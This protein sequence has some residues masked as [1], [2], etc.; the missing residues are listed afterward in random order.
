MIQRYEEISVQHAAH[1]ISNCARSDY[2]RCFAAYRNI[3][4]PPAL[5]WPKVA[6]DFGVGAPFWTLGLFIG[7]AIG[8][9]TFT[10]QL[11]AIFALMQLVALFIL[12]AFRY[13]LYWLSDR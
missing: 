10:A 3:W 12:W 6:W 5:S 4:G 1:S 9:R 7:Y 8:R 13:P 2:L 11:V